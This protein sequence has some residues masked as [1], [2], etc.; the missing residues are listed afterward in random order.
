MERRSGPLLVVLSGLPRPIVPLV[1][2]A[3][4]VGGLSLPPAPA[5]GCLGVLALLVGWLSYLSWPVLLAK[6]RLIRLAT[7]GLVLVALVQRLLV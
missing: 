3:L 7:A 2:L 5:A 4:L 6:A 1:S